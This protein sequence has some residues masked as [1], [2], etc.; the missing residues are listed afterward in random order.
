MT[1]NVLLGPWSEGSLR[2]SAFGFLKGGQSFAQVSKKATLS[3]IIYLD[4]VLTFFGRLGSILRKP[5]GAYGNYRNRGCPSALRKKFRKL[6][7]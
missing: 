6:R 7:G 4:Q 1:G 5:Y 2:P 3:V